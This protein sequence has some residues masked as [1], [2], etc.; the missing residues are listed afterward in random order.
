M[1][2]LGLNDLR[3]AIFATRPVPLAHEAYPYRLYLYQTRTKNCYPILAARRGYTRTR[4]LLVASTSSAVMV[5]PL[6][7]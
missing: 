1:A 5:S 6:P 3:E 7:S 2:Y 4:D